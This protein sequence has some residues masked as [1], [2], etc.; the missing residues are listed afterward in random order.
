MRT[1]FRFGRC[2]VIAALLGAPGASFALDAARI[3]AL[4]TGVFASDK[5]EHGSLSFTAGLMIGIP[6]RSPAAAFG[7]SL[8]LGVGKEL[9]DRRRSH[10]DWGDLTAD[11]LGAAA[12]TAV[13]TRLRH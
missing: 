7:G 9:W 1:P 11:A 10:F 13:T 5:L 4:Q 3:R 8:V 6:T 2:L 12:A